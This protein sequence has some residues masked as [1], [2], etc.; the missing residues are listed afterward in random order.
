M[1]PWVERPTIEIDL[2]KPLNSRYAG[3]PAQAFDLGRELLDAMKR[4]IP[5]KARLLAHWVR[6]RT[7]NRFH[8]EAVSLA[9]AGNHDWR[10]IMLAQHIIMRPRQ[11][12]IRLFV[13]RRFVGEINVPPLENRLQVN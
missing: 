5:A 3:I 9:R 8:G 7:W 6:L 10:D 11:G 12:T 13:P 1:V 4:E 2:S